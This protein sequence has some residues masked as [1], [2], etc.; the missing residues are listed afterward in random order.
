MTLPSLCVCVLRTVMALFYPPGVSKWRHAE[1]VT[2][3]LPLSLSPFAF[4]A[5]HVYSAIVVLLQADYTCE[6]NAEQPNF[7]YVSTHMKGESKRGA[8][9]IIFDS[10]KDRDIGWVAS[11]AFISLRSF[12]SEAPILVDG[13]FLRSVLLCSSPRIAPPPSPPHNVSTSTILSQ[14]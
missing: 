7:P 3:L 1:T 4:I 8:H 14:P 5:P 11:P 6:F 12:R 9:D 2:I 10:E 13:W